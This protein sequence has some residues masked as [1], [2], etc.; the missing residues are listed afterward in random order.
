MMSGTIPALVTPFDRDGELNL[1]VVPRLVRFLLERSIGGFFV[2]GSTGEAFLMTPQERMALA[3]AVVREV[4][5]AVPVV[6]HVGA[7][8]VRAVKIMAQHAQSIGADAVSS[9]LPFYYQYGVEEIRGYFKMIAE[10]S[11][12]PV[13]VYVLTQA[14]GLPGSPAAFAERVLGLDGVAGLKYTGSEV[15][16]LWNLLRLTGGRIRAYG[17]DDKYVLPMLVNGA[18]GVIG[19]NYS[20]YPEPFCAIYEAWQRGDLGQAQSAYNRA[21]TLLT[22]LLGIPGQTRAKE[23]LCLRGIDVGR[24]RPPLPQITEDQRALIRQTLEEFELL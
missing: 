15:Y 1:Q 23:A 2:G 8:D 5:G 9:V 17:G 16:Q 4:A 7:M 14:G 3:D 20:A 10:T 22:R 18:S 19:S 6:V 12:L 11:Q 13:I 24:T 21:L